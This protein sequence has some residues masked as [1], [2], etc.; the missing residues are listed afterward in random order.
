MGGEPETEDQTACQL[1]RGAFDA[2]ADRDVDRLRP[3]WDERTTTVFVALGL[4]LTG[5][6]AL[7]TFFD[8]FFTAVPDLDFTVEAIHGLDGH[9]AVGQWRVAATF[10]GGPFQGI[11]PTGRPVEL[12]GVDVMRFDDGM[13][14]RNDV[15]Y[16]GLAFARQIGLL[17]AA[18]S[19][20]DRAMLATFNALSRLRRRLRP[21]S[22]R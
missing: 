1:M 10:S 4:E 22:V 21:R 14:R 2:V 9:T 13:L 15:Y 7:R 16:D 8:E 12:R 5:E 11:E 6:P 17:P 18:D 19:A 3:L 20:T